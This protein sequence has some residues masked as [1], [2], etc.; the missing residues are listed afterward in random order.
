[1]N[2]K[3]KEQARKAWAWI[4]AHQQTVKVLAALLLGFGLGWWV[5]R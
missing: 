5:G 3:H 1:M 4:L 2:D